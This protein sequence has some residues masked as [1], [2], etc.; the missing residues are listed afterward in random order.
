M[1]PIVLAPMFGAA[2]LAAGCTQ[3]SR[4]PVDGRRPV[5]TAQPSLPVLQFTPVP[6]AAAQGTYVVKRGDTLYSIALEQG[7]DY[8]ELAQWNGLDDPSR[9]RVGQEL[10]IAA[11]P[12]RSAAQIGT[13]RVPGEIE[14]RPLGPGAAGVP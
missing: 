10:R 14:A 8:R 11:P 7:V 13:A 3:R 5:P 2:L 4:A 6:G 9:I 1:R 12:D